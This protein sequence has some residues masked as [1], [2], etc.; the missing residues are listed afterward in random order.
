[1]PGEGSRRANS[2]RAIAKSKAV[3]ARTRGTGDEH[4][5]AAEDPLAA[6]LLVEPRDARAN[7]RRGGLVIQLQRSDR[8]H[9]DAAL[10]QTSVGRP[11]GSP[12]PVLFHRGPGCR[13]VIWAGFGRRKRQLSSS[14]LPPCSTTLVATAHGSITSRLDRIET[15]LSAGRWNPIRADDSD[16]S[17]VDVSAPERLCDAGQLFTVALTGPKGRIA[18]I[19]S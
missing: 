7:A 6:Q 2:L 18:Q 3:L 10:P 15:R 19:R 17:F 8:Q 13:W 12:P 16:S 4:A 9:R 5:A 1:V 11:A 14:S